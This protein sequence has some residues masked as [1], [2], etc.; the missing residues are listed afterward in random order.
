MVVFDDGKATA[1]VNMCWQEKA[2]A[3]SVLDVP[4]EPDVEVAAA[5]EDHHQRFYHPLPP[6]APLLIII[7][8]NPIAIVIHLLIAIV[9]LRTATRQQILLPYLSSQQSSGSSPHP[10]PSGYLQCFGRWTLVHDGP[11]KFVGIRLYS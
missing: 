1:L 3:A 5:H 11:N 7:V 4:E 6:L 9:L 10:L 2:R 8:N